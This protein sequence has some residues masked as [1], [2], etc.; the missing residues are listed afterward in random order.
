MKII[1]LVLD[2]MQFV[3]DRLQ[4]NIML[5]FILISLSLFFLFLFYD[6]LSAV[7]CD[8]DGLIKTFII[9]MR[10][11][12][13]A[14]KYINDNYYSMIDESYIVNG[15]FVNEFNPKTF[16]DL[17]G[18]LQGIEISKETDVDWDQIDKTVEESISTGEPIETIEDFNSTKEDEIKKTRI[19]NI[20]RE[21]MLSILE[22]ELEE[23]IEYK[24]YT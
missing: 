15:N 20:V 13:D 16:G 3:L 19:E 18:P 5:E 23:D 21:C 22:E 2:G 6:I 1:I 12:Y 7:A 24:G 9:S 17:G 14:D 4:S 10:K 8:E 11:D